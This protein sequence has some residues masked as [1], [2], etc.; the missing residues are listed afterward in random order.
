MALQERIA[1]HNSTDDIRPLIFDDVMDVME[2]DFAASFVWDERKQV[3]LRGIS[4]QIPEHKMVEYAEWLHTCDPISARLRRFRR[5]A[6]VEEA[7]P[8]ERLH[9][10]QFYHEFLRPVGM[11]SGMNVFL[12]DGDEDIGDFRI[13]RSSDRAPFTRA[14]RQLL[15]LLAGSIRR[16]ILRQ[17]AVFGGLTARESDVA[18][19]VAKGCRDQDIARVLGISLSTVRT[20][21]RSA[22]EKR[23]CANR[24][25]LAVSVTSR[26]N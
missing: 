7:M 20:H 14:D 8:Y 17:K 13:W 15:D 25:E 4:Y 24:A 1:L 3:S 21:L 6:L 5:A 2:A 12:F 23:G 10:T 19:L 9:Q 11:S 16:A 18:L 22:Q 26:H